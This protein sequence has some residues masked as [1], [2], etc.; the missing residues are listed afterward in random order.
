MCEMFHLMVKK[1]HPDARLPSVAHPGD[2]ACDLFA[3]EGAEI[4]AGGQCAVRTG[5][6]LKFPDGWGGIIKD[7]SS[8]A[9]A[10]I[11]TSGGVIDSGYRGEVKIILRND[12][13]KEFRIQAG[14]KIAQMMAQKAEEWLVEEAESLDETSRAQGGFGS[15]GKK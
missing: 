15:T 13:G 10:R 5:V 14:D 8:M 1:L 6:A 9:I 12:S 3:L 2:L 4:P 11:Y 7:R